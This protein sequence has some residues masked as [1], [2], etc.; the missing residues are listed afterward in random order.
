MIRITRTFINQVARDMRER[1]VSIRSV[2][3]L[4]GESERSASGIT[5]V[6]EISNEFSKVIYPLVVEHWT[7]ETGQK[8]LPKEQ[9]DL[10][11]RSYVEELLSSSNLAVLSSGD[12]N[13]V[14]IKALD[15]YEEVTNI[16][17]TSITRESGLNKIKDS[18]IY[19]DIINSL[20]S[21]ATGGLK[22][23]SFNEIKYTY[24][25]SKDSSS[26]KP[27]DLINENFSK[28]LT[29]DD[30]D[31]LSKLLDVYSDNKGLTSDLL[32]QDI[33]NRIVSRGLEQV[34]YIIE[35]IDEGESISSMFGTW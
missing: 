27:G 10:I 12:W 2:R 18:K 25:V 21:K 34:N 3:G 28:L 15:N 4:I 35:K 5:T 31:S 29:M 1:G 30:I 14:A 16:R 32:Y 24:A 8:T 6:K 19:W 9:Y 26:G 20:A 17:L 22:G 33:K 23:R 7:S 11:K 13:S